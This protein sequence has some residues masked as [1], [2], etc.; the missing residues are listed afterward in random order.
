[1][2]YIYEFRLGVSAFGVYPGFTPVTYPYLL[3]PVLPHCE[4]L[5]LE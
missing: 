3:I 4:L 1:M 5:R 2:I